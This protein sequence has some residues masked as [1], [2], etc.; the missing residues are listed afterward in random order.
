MNII[1]DGKLFV[2]AA[3][4]II[5]EFSKFYD[6]KTKRE[7]PLKETLHNDLVFKYSPL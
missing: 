7:R 1:K 2:F 5:W 6:K 3:K 4:A